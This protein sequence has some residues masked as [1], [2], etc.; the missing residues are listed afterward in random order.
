[1]LPVLLLFAV[2]AAISFRR[3]A[4]QPLEWREVQKGL[5]VLA[6][7]LP[8]LFALFY[9]MGRHGQPLGAFINA[10]V[11][12]SGMS[13]LFGAYYDERYRHYWGWGLST[14]LFGVSMPLGSYQTAGVFAGCWL[15]LGG[16]STASIMAW[17]LRKEN[18]GVND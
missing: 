18:E 3:K 5:V 2:G 12:F 9:W 10:G 1:M 11:V 14:L 13:W 15:L 4:A 16:L 17:R 8:L 7:S 6:V